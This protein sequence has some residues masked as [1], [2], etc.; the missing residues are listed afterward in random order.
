ML[1]LVVIYDECL[2]LDSVSNFFSNVLMNETLTFVELFC[3]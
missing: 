1:G 3:M 2:S